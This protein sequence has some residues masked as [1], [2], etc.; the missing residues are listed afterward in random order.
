MMYK[1]Q[2][3]QFTHSHMVGHTD[4]GFSFAHGCIKSDNGVN[5]VSVNYPQAINF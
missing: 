2:A 3:S 1:A 5:H 4:F